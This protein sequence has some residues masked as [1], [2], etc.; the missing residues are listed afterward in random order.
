MKRKTKS[1]KNQQAARKSCCKAHS[2]G[3]N[4]LT[5]Q[6]RQEKRDENRGENQ[7][8]CNSQVS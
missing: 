8:K 3:G 1:Y 7:G 2:L 4:G 5:G 6:D